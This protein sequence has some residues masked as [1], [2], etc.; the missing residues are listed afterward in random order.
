MLIILS[1][2]LNLTLANNQ[3]IA[4]TA[5]CT[6]MLIKH[7]YNPVYCKSTCETENIKDLK[8]MCLAA[9][10]CLKLGN[11]ALGLSPFDK[12]TIVKEVLN[13]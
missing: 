6:N 2:M 4:T 9:C 3:I 7:G 1:L 5:E 11:M 13:K 12:S 10:S 8:N